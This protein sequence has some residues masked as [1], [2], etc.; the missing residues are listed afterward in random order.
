LSAELPVTG[1]SHLQCL[2]RLLT[3][4]PRSLAEVRPDLP[5]DLVAVVDALR[6][7]NP[8]DRPAT[9]EEAVALLEPVASM[10]LPKS[11]VVK[12]AGV[13]EGGAKAS[14]VLD[15]LQGRLSAEAACERH[16]LTPAEFEQWR[17]R[18]LEGAR[19]A[20]ELARPGEDLV[21]ELRG[22]IEAQAREVARL[23]G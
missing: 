1:K 19:K 18:F 7:R 4:P 11:G 12:V 15:V 23:R 13:V 3:Q 8:E 22:K 5:P 6:C 2:H 16:G 20:F 10:K 14:L 17:K 21:R 9:A